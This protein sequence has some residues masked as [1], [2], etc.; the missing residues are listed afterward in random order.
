MALASNEL[1]HLKSLIETLF[2]YTENER[3]FQIQKGSTALTPL[4]AMFGFVPVVEGSDIHLYIKVGGPDNVRFGRVVE[5]DGGFSKFPKAID[6]FDRDRLTHALMDEPKKYGFTKREVKSE[7]PFRIIYKGGYQLQ[8]AMHADDDYKSVSTNPKIKA[9]IVSGIVT[10]T[11]EHLGLMYGSEQKSN[12]QL[13]LKA[14]KDE[15]SVGFILKMF[16]DKMKTDFTNYFT[17]VAEFVHNAKSGS[18]M[19]LIDDVQT[20]SDAAFEG[21]LSY[22]RTKDYNR[23]YSTASEFVEKQLTLGKNEVLAAIE[24][25]SSSTQAVTDNVASYTSLLGMSTEADIKRIEDLNASKASL[26]EKNLRLEKE[27]KETKAKVPSDSNLPKYLGIGAGAV[28]A[29]IAVQQESAQDL[30]TWQKAA[31]VAIGGL[32]GAVPTLNLVTIA[33]T[34]YLVNK[35]MELSKDEEFK[36]RVKTRAGELRDRARNLLPQGETPQEV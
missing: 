7:F 2:T 12:V 23:N 16:M 17:K 9:N 15:T 10:A 26:T 14:S 22:P 18:F 36:G 25:A 30:E 20:L 6:A 24:N 8:Y 11:I 29:F 21:F 3:T 1:N 27:L 31:I 28:S 32:L 5:S 35:G 4:K 34:P 33:T 13:L 19:G